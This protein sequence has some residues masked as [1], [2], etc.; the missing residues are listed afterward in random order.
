MYN[1]IPRNRRVSIDIARPESGIKCIVPAKLFDATEE[2]V[3]DGNAITAL[4][5]KRGY[6]IGCALSIV[7][8]EKRKAFPH[9]LEI[10]VVIATIAY[11]L[12]PKGR[13]WWAVRYGHEYKHIVDA[14]DEGNLKRLVEE[15]PDVLSGLKF[16][17]VKDHST[18]RHL[19]SPSKIAEKAVAANPE[20]SI[21]LIAKEAGVGRTTVSKARRK[22]KKATSVRRVIGKDN[23][24]YAVHKNA[25]QNSA[26]KG[27]IRRAIKA[28]IVPKNF[29]LRRA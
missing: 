3:I 28:G 20:K 18:S 29:K 27:A 16:S 11:A 7:A 13:D 23:K 4:R 12:F 10:M 22:N 21:G 14:N 17:P 24:S 8:E 19:S 2:V 5:G 26:E 1:L 9:P 6:S 25:G 15:N